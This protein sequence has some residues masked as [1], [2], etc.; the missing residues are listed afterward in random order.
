M[1]EVSAPSF[2]RRKVAGVPV[3]YLLGGVAVILAVLAYRMKDTTSQ[4]APDPEALEVEAAGEDALLAGTGDTSGYDAFVA[5]GSITA[6]P[7][8]TDAAE[9]PDP[10]NEG[11]IKLGTEWL[12]TQG[13]SGGA[14][15]RALTLY[16]QGEQLTFEQGVWRD[17]VIVKFGAP[18]ES[19]SPGPT[20]GAPVAPA[21][22]QG[23]PPLLHVVKGEND[24]AFKELTQLYYGKAD[25]ATIDFLQ[26]ANGLG[27][28][29]PFAVGT[30]VTIPRYAAPKYY[31]STK[32]TDTASEIARKNGI[33]TTALA[34]LNDGM[35]FPVKSGTKVRVG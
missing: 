35:K 27:S 5:N 12:A 30:K 21:Q 6:A 9:K 19:I 33:S 17:K 31:T 8:E 22:R 13:V 23:N 25:N 2:M 1:S 24:N 18:P 26:A 34:H 15:Q 14:A 7:P 11:W 4:D 29:G 32:T 16:V 3:V 10:T 20:S 28:T